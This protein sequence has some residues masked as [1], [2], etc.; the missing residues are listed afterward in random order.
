MKLLFKTTPKTSH[1][2]RIGIALSWII[3]FP[4]A[5][6][7]SQSEAAIYGFEFANVGVEKQEWVLRCR[8]MTPGSAQLAVEACSRLLQ[9]PYFRSNPVEK[10]ALLI[11]RSTGWL[12][13]GNPIAAI[14]DADVASKLEPNSAMVQNQRCWAR[15][16]A[17]V[18]LRQAMA[19]CLRAIRI[20]GASVRVLDSLALIRLRRQQWEQAVVEYDLASQAGS[21]SSLY[22]KLLGQIGWAADAKTAPEFGRFLSDVK[23]PETRALLDNELRTRE[24]LSFAIMG[25]DEQTIAAH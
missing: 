18:Q 14:R 24:A 20:G 6:A 16:A 2:L 22:G 1:L 10:S 9:D 25:I 19:A 17:N 21:T 23:I 12:L 5:A 11:N 3:P 8:N 7:P 13:V 15:A 4:C